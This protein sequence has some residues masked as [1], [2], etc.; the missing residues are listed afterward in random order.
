MQWQCEEGEEG[1]LQI[2]HRSKETIIAI[3]Q[4]LTD[5]QVHSVLD[6]RSQAKVHMDM[7]APSRRLDL[8]E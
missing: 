7:E 1:H 4:I 8:P 3:C 2:T 6:H 5:P